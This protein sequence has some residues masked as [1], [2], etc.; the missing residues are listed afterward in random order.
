MDKKQ[1]TITTD[2]MIEAIGR[3][4]YLIETRI[5][6]ELLKAGYVTNMNY[7]LPDKKS[8]TPRELDIVAWKNLP[9][10]QE[11]EVTLNLC[12]ECGNNPQ[13]LVIFHRKD[14]NNPILE[15][16]DDVKI[17]GLE[18][19]FS[20]DVSQFNSFGG[21]VRWNHSS[22]GIT[23][24]QYCSFNQKKN[25]GSWMT[26]HEDSHF[27]LFDKLLDTEKYYREG[28]QQ[29]PFEENSLTVGFF[30]YICVLGGD[31]FKCEVADSQHQISEID[32]GRIVFSRE[33]TLG[34]DI[35]AVQVVKE[36]S[37]LKVI[38]IIEEQAKQFGEIIKTNRSQ[39]LTSHAAINQKNEP[40]IR[41]L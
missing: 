40:K 1:Q 15:I 25:G 8:A 6:D 14:S 2:E 16:S 39:R 33:H 26:Y 19:S 24:S 30:S 17:T 34:L 4:G 5:S 37:F 31:L 13:P 21:K 12:I 20:D 27:S 36:R 11:D 41:F 10:Y 3:S 22:L 35:V 7:S 28:L 38:N 32:H 18:H 23:G 9:S 29:S